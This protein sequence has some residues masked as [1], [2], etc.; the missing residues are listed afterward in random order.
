M[1]V[2]LQ[3]ADQGSDFKFRQNFKSF[4]PPS[5]KEVT[6]RELNL[7]S[8][9]D[10]IVFFCGESSYVYAHPTLETWIS[11]TTVND[12]AKNGDADLREGS[13]FHVLES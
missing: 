1:K 10:S 5:K 8:L 4:K 13:D 12:D 2:V 7:R 11:V 9:R 3:L 6:D